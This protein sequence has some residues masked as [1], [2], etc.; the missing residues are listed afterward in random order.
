MVS[1]NSIE[2]LEACHSDNQ[3]LE[4]VAVTYAAT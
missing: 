1:R 2:F 4:V 3:F